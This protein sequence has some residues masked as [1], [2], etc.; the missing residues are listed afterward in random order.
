MT[1]TP[2][3]IDYKTRIIFDTY[4]GLRLMDY[5]EP[6]AIRAL[7]ILGIDPETAKAIAMLYQESWKKEMD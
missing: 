1:D 5:N 3:A 7:T 4:A 6:G 2:T